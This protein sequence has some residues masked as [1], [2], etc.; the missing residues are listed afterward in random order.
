MLTHAMAFF[1]GIFFAA[2]LVIAERK[3]C[4]REH[5]VY[6]CVMTFVPKTQQ[7]EQQND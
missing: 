1:L 7:K 5:N 4:E 6:E 2:Q 3:E